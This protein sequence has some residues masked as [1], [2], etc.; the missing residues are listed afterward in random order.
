MDRSTAVIDLTEMPEAGD[1]TPEGSTISTADADLKDAGAA[2][3]FLLKDLKM[4]TGTEKVKNYDVE[5]AP[6]SSSSYP[7]YGI[8]QEAIYVVFPYPTKLYEEDFEVDL[9]D[10][11]YYVQ[12]KG[13]SLLGS[14]GTIAQAEVDLV[15]QARIIAD[16][17][18]GVPADELTAGAIRLRDLL[19]RIV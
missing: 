13:S 5:N 3:E 19:M 1:T 4:F 12:H 15:D 16:M 11:V 10:N 14:G 18:I 2:V 7:K 9:E 8:P 6:V 17:Y